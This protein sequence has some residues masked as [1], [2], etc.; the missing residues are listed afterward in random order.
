M[1]WGREGIGLTTKAW[2]NSEPSRHFSQLSRTERLTASG[3]ACWMPYVILVLSSRNFGSAWMRSRPGEGNP[4]AG[5]GA[6]EPDSWAGA[7]GSLRCT[8]GEDW[9]RQTGLFWYLEA[10]VA[11]AVAGGG[12]VAAGVGRT[13]AGEARSGTGGEGSA[14]E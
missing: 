6:E 1:A 7:M 10:L 8:L 13:A 12:W 5:G 9:A 3:M 2:W 4:T 11:V 14:G